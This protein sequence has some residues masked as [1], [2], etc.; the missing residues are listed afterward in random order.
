[1]MII[2]LTNL[3]KKGQKDGEIDDKNKKLDLYAY[4]I[5]CC[6]VDSIEHTHTSLDTTYILQVE[7]K[8]AL[9]H[10]LWWL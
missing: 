2:L 10:C 7:N 1:M 9:A 5:R 8:H 6:D 4:S 3:G